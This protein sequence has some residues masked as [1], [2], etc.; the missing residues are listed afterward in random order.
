VHLDDRILAQQRLATPWRLRARQFGEGI[1]RAACDAERN[2]GKSGRYEP[3][4]GVI[5][6]NGRSGTDGTVGSESIER[7]RMTWRLEV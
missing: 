5:S 1:K 3:R 7:A 2:S 4:A 6:R